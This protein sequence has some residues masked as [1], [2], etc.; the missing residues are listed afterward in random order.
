MQQQYEQHTNPSPYAVNPYEKAA[1]DRAAR[2]EARRANAEAVGRHAAPA[3]RPSRTA[4]RVPVPVLVA[5]VAAVVAIVAIVVALVSC[6][7]V[8][9]SDAARQET[10]QQAPLQTNVDANAPADG[11]GQEPAAAQPTQ[12]DVSAQPA[13]SQALSAGG[14]GAQ[15][16]SIVEAQADA[17]PQAPWNLVLVNATHPIP[18]D[19]QVGNILELRNGQS[20]DE[21]IYPELQSMFDNCRAAG[22]DPYINSSYRS[23]ATQVSIMEDRVA[24]YIEEGYSEAE[25]RA[26]AEFEVALPGT[27]EHEIGL[28]LDIMSER[29]DYD[30]NAEV[31]DWLAE[32][33]WAYGFI[34]RYPDDKTDITGITGEPWHF[35][36]VGVEA[37]QEMHERNLCLEEYLLEKYG[38]E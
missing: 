19:Y 35:R 38:I 16:A 28:A 29:E 24:S 26:Q 1:S 17:E 25:A 7:G 18:D 3:A 11:G 9:A 14:S 37:A 8:S 34:L 22:L 2:R 13:Q 6:G 33:G 21:R 5:A 20:V 30:A 23:H 15:L 4:P 36:Y 10:S 12:A 27:S 32:N 31:R